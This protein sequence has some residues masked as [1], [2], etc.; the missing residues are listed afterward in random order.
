MQPEQTPTPPTNPSESQSGAQAQPQKP[1]EH[2][3]SLLA[4][5]LL[6][7]VIPTLVLTK[8]SK[9]AYLG[10]TL[11]LLVALAFPLGYGLYHYWRS[12]KINLFSAI[13][14]VSVLLT[15]GISLL[16]LPPEYMAIKEAAIPGLLGL[17]TLI[18]I[19]TPYPLVRTFLYNDKV[20]DVAKVHDALEKYGNVE[21]F[22]KSLANAT[23]MLAGSFFLSSVLNYA[24][25]KWVLVSPPGTEQYNAELG[26][27]TALSFPVITIP[28]MAVFMAAV[29]YLFRSIT[30]LTHLHWEDILKQTSAGSR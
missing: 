19:Y 2:Q 17:A 20:M 8:G 15:G 4:N 12:R 26:T 1:K 28:S 7:I 14:L 25:A 10:P 22:E 30:R 9:E 27:M 23:Y 13:G 3:E 18:S 24:L 16:K 21:A 6:N 5:L 29:F 11:G